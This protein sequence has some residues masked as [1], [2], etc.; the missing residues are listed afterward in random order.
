MAAA[1]ALLMALAVLVIYS[2]VVVPLQSW[3]R[4]DFADGPAA[5]DDGTQVGEVP[6]A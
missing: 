1:T 6:A 4:T 5:L 2:I 3:H